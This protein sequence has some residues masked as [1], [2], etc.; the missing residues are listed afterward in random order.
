MRGDLYWDDDLGRSQKVFVVEKQ[1]LGRRKDAVLAGWF[2]CDSKVGRRHW[3][4][5]SV[6]VAEEM[7]M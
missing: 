4:G 1:S 7:D 5:L 2:D 6:L 3:E